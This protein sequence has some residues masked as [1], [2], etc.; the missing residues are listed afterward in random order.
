M[1]KALENSEQIPSLARDVKSRPHSFLRVH[2]FWSVIH[3]IH[4]KAEKTEA[5]ALKDKELIEDGDCHTC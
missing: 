5:T 1:R 4:R 2:S 3:L